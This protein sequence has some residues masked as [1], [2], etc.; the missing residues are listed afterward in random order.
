MAQWLG[1]FM[2]LTHDSKV[3]ELE[4]ALVLAIVAFKSAGEGPEKALKAKALRG[5]AKRVLAAQRRA[6]KAKIVAAQRVPTEEALE[7]RAQ[8]IARLR[9]HQE[10]LA[11]CSVADILVELG[12]KEAS[13]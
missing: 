4:A 10:Q 12:V 3:K 6:V 1:Q 5:L 9:E 8:E 2:G 11:A 7:L 13:A